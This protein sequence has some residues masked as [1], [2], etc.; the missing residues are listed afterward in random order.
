[1]DKRST[2]TRDESFLEMLRQLKKDKLPASMLLDCK[3]LIR[4]EGIVTDIVSNADHQY[5]VLQSGVK[6]DLSTLVAVN[7]V[8]LSGYSEC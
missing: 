8:F 5:F 6:I 7:G 3:G 1:M 4:A 2:I